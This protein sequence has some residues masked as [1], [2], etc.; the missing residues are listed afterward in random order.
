MFYYG[1]FYFGIIF[2][3][4]LN[5]LQDNDGRNVYILKGLEELVYSD[6]VH[7]SSPAVEYENLH[8]MYDSQN[9][10]MFLIY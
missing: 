5:F 1:L 3:T 10:Y 4:A 9:I 7:K 6:S 2:K 8:L